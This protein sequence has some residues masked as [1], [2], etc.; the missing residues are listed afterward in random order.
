MAVNMAAAV[1]IKSF[2]A[3]SKSFSVGALCT[4]FES[5]K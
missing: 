4:N 5:P 3:A 2:S 1:F